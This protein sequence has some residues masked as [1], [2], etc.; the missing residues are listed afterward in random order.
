MIDLTGQS[1]PQLMR[2]IVCDKIGMRDSTNEQPLPPSR[3]G[4]A[5]S[6]TYAN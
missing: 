4:S 1:F 2:E 6:E 5:G 3:L